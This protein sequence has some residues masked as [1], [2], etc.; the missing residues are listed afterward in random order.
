MNS[1]VGAKIV[2]GACS[3]WISEIDGSSTPGKTSRNDV[4]AGATGRSGSSARPSSIVVS[5]KD[6]L[7]GVLWTSVL[8]MVVGWVSCFIFSLIASKMAIRS[9]TD[10]V[11]AMDSVSTSSRILVC[12]R[13]YWLLWP[14]LLT[15]KIRCDT[16]KSNYHQYFVC[17]IKPKQIINEFTKKNQSLMWKLYCRKTLYRDRR[18]ISRL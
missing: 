13:L 1:C 15:R 7:S 5:I 11:D 9:R 18:T 6:S 17:T 8:C 4:L 14:I 16:N 3:A 12:S 10:P 2:P